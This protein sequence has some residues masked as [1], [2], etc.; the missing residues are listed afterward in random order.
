RALNRLPLTATCIGGTLWGGSAA[1][2][3]RTVR[4]ATVFAALGVYLYAVLAVAVIGAAGDP[5]DN[6]WTDAQVIGDRVGNQF[7]FYLVALPVVTVAVGWAAAAATA[8]LHH[9][10]QPTLSVPSVT[11]PRVRRT[12]DLL[13]LACAGLGAVALVAL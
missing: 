3:R 11:A 1:A 2:G 13:V 8:R 12:A 4:L 5:H 10:V 9:T 6:G 7:V